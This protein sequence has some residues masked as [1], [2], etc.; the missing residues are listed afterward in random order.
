MKKISIVGVLVTAADWILHP[1]ANY[2]ELQE[3]REDYDKEVLDFH[4]Q[5]ERLNGKIEEKEQN[6][7]KIS[8]KYDRVR[9]KLSEAE[10]NKDELKKKV[11]DMKATIRS[12]EQKV[13]YRNNVIQKNRNT[14]TELKY[15]IG[16]LEEQLNDAR[17]Q[18]VALA[19]KVEFYEKQNK[20]SAKEKI[21]YLMG[22]SKKIENNS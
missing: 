2:K 5:L 20:K 10:E 8:A 7:C 21:D 11:R 14:N 22:R 9:T 12:L 17:N 1:V 15:Q 16:Q 3:Y 13:I 18:V 19:K 6:L 4:K